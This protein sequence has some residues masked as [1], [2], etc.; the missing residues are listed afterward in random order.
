MG[1]QRRD[2]EKTNKNCHANIQTETGRV[3]GTPM[4]PGFKTSGS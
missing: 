3:N 1:N 4:K 2:I